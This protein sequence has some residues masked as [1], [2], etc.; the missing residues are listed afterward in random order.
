VIGVVGLAAAAAI[1]AVR[2]LPARTD[3][4]AKAAAEP[5]ATA[6]PV[7]SP[8]RRG[9]PLLLSIAMIDSATRMGF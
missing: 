2:G 9:F 1:L 5:T 8:T 7:A 4:T 3:Q 6:Q